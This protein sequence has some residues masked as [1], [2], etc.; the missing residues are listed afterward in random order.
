MS[1]VI[2]VTSG[3]LGRA[4][5]EAVLDRSTDPAEVIAGARDWPRSLTT[6]PEGCTPRSST[7]MTPPPLRR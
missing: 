3:H 4:A 6:P 2:T 7:T 5:V 1:I